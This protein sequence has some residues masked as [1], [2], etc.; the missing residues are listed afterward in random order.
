MEMDHDEIILDEHDVLWIYGSIFA[1][2]GILVLAIV[3]GTR[4]YRK[5]GA[6]IR[7]ANAQER[8][9]D[10]LEAGCR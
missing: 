9:A 7:A 5:A 10:A 6:D 8:I 4:L 2:A 1:L 3:L